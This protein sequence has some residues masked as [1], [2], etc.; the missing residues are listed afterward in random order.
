MPKAPLLSD[1]EIEEHLTRLP[2]WRR[3]NNRIVR[4]FEF[5]DFRGALDFL[6]T[7]ADVADE[8][9]HHPDVSI[10]WNEM[11]LALWTHASGGITERDVGLADAIDR[12][13]ED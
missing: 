3:E 8:R 12:L 10:H 5:A 1:S 2:A 9:N 13:M 4:T 7:V 6:T 11:T